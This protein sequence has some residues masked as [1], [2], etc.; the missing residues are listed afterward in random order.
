MHFLNRTA[1]VTGAAGRIGRAVAQA[2]ARYGVK[3][4]L[5]DVNMERL[6][7]LAEELRRDHPE[8]HTVFM[9]VSDLKSMEDAAQTIWEKAGRVDILVNNAGVWPRG[10]ALECCDEDWQRIINLNLHSV[11]RLSKIFGQRMKEQQYG[12]IINLGSIAGEVGLPEFCAYSVAKAGVIM[13]TKN[14]AMEL[15]KCGVT[16]NCVSPGMIG[17]EKGPCAG[18]WLGRNGTGDEVANAIVFLAA[19]E[20]GYI[21]GI[22]LTVDGGRILGPLTTTFQG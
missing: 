21:T 5:A 16:V 19:D 13:L 17:D 2:F 15:A 6:E 7:A 11:F 10:S 3:L 8:I 4:Y 1:V 18:T 14:M 12:R 20:S 9:D 22:D